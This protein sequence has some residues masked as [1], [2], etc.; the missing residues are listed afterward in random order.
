[1]TEISKLF[2]L[3]VIAIPDLPPVYGILHSVQHHYFQRPGGEY[4]GGTAVIIRYTQKSGHSVIV[5]KPNRINWA[6]S[7][8]KM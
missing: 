4:Q 2:I 1:M 6:G 3:F 5:F 7:K 8:F